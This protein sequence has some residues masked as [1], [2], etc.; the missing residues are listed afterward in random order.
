M[1]GLRFEPRDAPNLWYATLHMEG[2]ADQVYDDIVVDNLF[3]QRAGIGGGGPRL[4]FKNSTVG[5]V[6]D[7][8]AATVGGYSHMTFDNV[9]WHDVVLSAA[10]VANGVHN[11]CVFAITVPDFTMKNSSFWNC[12]TMDLFFT[13]GQWWSTPPPPRYDNVTI[14]NNVFS[15][16]RFGDVDG[17]HVGLGFQY[18]ALAIGQ[19]GPTTTVPADPLI[20]WTIRN[21]TFERRMCTEARDAVD[22]RWVNNLGDWA[23]LD[24]VIYRHNVG[25]TCPGGV[26]EVS[27][28]PNDNNCAPQDPWV[29]LEA[30]TIAGFNWADP[31]DNDFRLTAGSPAI[32]AGDPLDAP[33]TDKN[34][35]PRVGAP[36]AGAYEYQG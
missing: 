21:N 28:T 30:N 13:H 14:E 16:P 20:G 35:D 31:A 11:E 29:C 25:Q 23:C 24:D 26:N 22:T 18:C 1:I 8:K 2:G 7:E 3:E 15:H 27:I 5:N 4:L 9:Y 19:N 34:G 17:D 12:A 32:D 6:T 33:A 10:G 36:D